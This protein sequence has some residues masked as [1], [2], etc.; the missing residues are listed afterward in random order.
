MLFMDK[1]IEIRAIPALR[2]NYIWRLAHAGNAVV[3]D[4]G[5]AEPVLQHLSRQGLDLKAILL[6]H[7]HNDHIGGVARLVEQTG[8]P[9]LGPAAISCVTCPVADGEQVEI[10]GLPARARILH[11]PGHLNEHIAWLFDG[12][13]FSG[14]ILFSAGC[15]RVFEG[16]P[17]WLYESLQKLR[18]LPPG[19]LF[20]PTHEY[21]LLNLRFAAHVEPDNPALPAFRQQVEQRLREYGCSLPTTMEQ[22]LQV[23]PFLRFNDSLCAAVERHSGERPATPEQLFVALRQWRNQF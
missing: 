10:P 1:A 9:V 7:R 13:C 8:V 5:E 19:T 23:N 21:T 4:P 22:E 16:D 12:H 14:D 20:Y 18:A 15:G 2:D 3:I 6:T 17:R 11:V